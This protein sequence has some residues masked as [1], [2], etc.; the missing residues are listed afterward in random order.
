MQ[1][2]KDLS[3]EELRALIAEVVEEKLQ[4]LLGDPDEGLTL[5]VEVRDRLVKSLKESRQLRPAAPAAEVAR[6]FGMA[7]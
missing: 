3:V 4:E 2:V 7:W 5:R 6:R 1:I